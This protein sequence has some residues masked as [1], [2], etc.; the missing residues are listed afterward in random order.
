MESK[1]SAAEE[2]APGRKA[3]AEAEHPQQNQ[4]QTTKFEK[5]VVWQIMNIYEYTPA[6][7]V[8]VT[9]HKKWFN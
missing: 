7:K 6:I 2:R 8:L 9:A 4:L 5:N 3:I 1:L